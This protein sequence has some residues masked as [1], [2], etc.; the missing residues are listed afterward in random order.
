MTGRASARSL[1]HVTPDLTDAEWALIEPLLPPPSCRGRPWTVDL[2]EVCNAI[3]YRL[4]TGGQWRAIPDGCPPLTTIQNSFYR[5]RDDGTLERLVDAL[6]TRAR[7]QA[8]RAVEPT[9]AARGPQLATKRR[10]MELDDRLEIITKPKERKGRTVRCRRRVVERT[11]GWMGRCRRL[12][13]DF[14]HSLASSLAW[15][16]LAVCRFLMRRVARGYVTVAY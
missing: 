12:A 14:E 10:E 1:L 4:A 8:G 9:A 16:Q 7:V 3:Q 5:W 11:F 15:V 13:K 6:R 2:R